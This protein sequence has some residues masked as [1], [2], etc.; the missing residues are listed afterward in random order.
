MTWRSWKLSRPSLYTLLLAEICILV[1]LAKLAGLSRKN[2]GFTSVDQSSPIIKSLSFHSAWSEGFLWTT[3]PTL[4]MILFRLSWSS[5]VDAL[6]DEA[7][8]RELQRESG[9]TMKQSV[10]LDY[11]RYS[12]FYSWVVALRNGNVLLGICMG[13]ALVNTIVLVPIAAHLFQ[14]VNPSFDRQASFLLTTSYNDSK[15]VASIDYAP[16]LS[17]VSAVRVHGGNWPLWTDGVYAFPAFSIPASASTSANVTELRPNITGYS[18]DLSCE[19]VTDYIISRTPSDGGTATLAISANDRGCDISIK[20]GVA[21]GSR[22]FLKTN[23]IIDCSAASG[24]SRISFFTGSYSATAP[25]LLD[26]MRVISC[27][28]RYKQTQ[29]IVIAPPSLQPISFDQSLGQSTD[30]RPSNWRGFEQD[31]L[32]LSNIGDSSSPDFTSG[33]GELILSL[34]RAGDSSPVPSSETLISSASTTFSSI[35]AVLAVTQLFQ[36]LS[37]PQSTPGALSVSETRLSVV[38]W[39]AYISIAILAILIVL[40]F[41]MIF[42]LSRK[43]SILPEEPRGVLGATSLLYNS[44]LRKLIVDANQTPGYQGEFY[45]W[46]EMNYVLGPEKCKVSEGRRIDVENLL[47]KP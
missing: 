36:P 27:I 3:L 25:Y 37:T 10:L 29:G 39:S 46:L 1:A 45:K 43:P 21:P 5:V 30:S 19:T 34:A 2:Q 18:A 4:L 17:V 42:Y 41:T 32:T 26:S 8:F 40:N 15:I 6:A 14:I 20:G 16:I 7:P 33:F 44:G 11:R 9:C 12:P 38:L 24:Y 13:L 28:P 22:V 31:M 47:K 23:S 35:F